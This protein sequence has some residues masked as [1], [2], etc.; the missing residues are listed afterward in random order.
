M[1]IA[2]PTFDGQ[3]IFGV[4]VSAPPPSIN[5]RREQRANYPGLD[6]TESLDLGDE[7][8]FTVVT[9]RLVGASIDDLQAAFGLLYGYYDGKS[10]TYVDSVGMSWPNAKVVSIEPEGMG[11]VDPDLGFTMKYSLKLFHL[12]LS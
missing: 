11:Q 1:S 3:S 9:G 6:G 12:T 10:Y 5:P 4:G 7:G 8:A 2:N